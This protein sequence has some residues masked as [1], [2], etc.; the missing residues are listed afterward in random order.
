MWNADGIWNIIKNTTQTICHSPICP[1]NSEMQSPESSRL[2]GSLCLVW[3]FSASIWCL[4]RFDKDVALPMT[5]P[6]FTD[7]SSH[8]CVKFV[9]HALFLLFTKFSRKLNTFCQKLFF[10]DS[11]S[12]S[13][14]E[15]DRTI[16]IREPFTVSA[17]SIVPDAAN[18]TFWRR[19]A[20]EATKPSPLF[21]NSEVI[22]ELI[23]KQNSINKFYQLQITKLFHLNC[24]THTFF[25]SAFLLCSCFSLECT[26]KN[27]IHWIILDAFERDIQTIFQHRCL[28]IN[29]KLFKREKCI[30]L[31]DAIPCVFCCNR[32]TCAP[33]AF[34]LVCSYE[35]ETNTVPTAGANC[36]PKRK[37]K[38]KQ[39]RH[40][41]DDRTDA[42]R[43]KANVRRHNFETIQIHMLRMESPAIRIYKSVKITNALI[44]I[45]RAIKRSRILSDAFD[46]SANNLLGIRIDGP[47]QMREFLLSVS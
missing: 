24:F 6:L 1:I 2:C 37:K 18:S 35:C 28:M 12:K 14:D 15:S 45:V 41:L 4:E 31:L 16:S 43:T 47:Y 26:E 21:L 17:V 42:K 22:S 25:L 33:Y 10:V 23:W 29:W 3:P 20:P 19:F 36:E 5:Q 38:Q 44:Q 8:L 39:Q 13:S 34:L 7:F 27:F 11:F 32:S 30:Y 46:A 40:Q 9:T